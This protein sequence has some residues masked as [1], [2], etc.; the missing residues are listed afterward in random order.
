M[1]RAWKQSKGQER[2]GH[3]QGHKAAL[4]GLRWNPPPTVAS[5][6]ASQALGGAAIL[7]QIGR[8]YLPGRDTDQS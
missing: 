3:G 8:I 1:M 2:K 6:W 4:G 5:A 7:S